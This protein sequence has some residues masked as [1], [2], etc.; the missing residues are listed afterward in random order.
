M[1]NAVLTIFLCS[2][3]GLIQ[4]QTTIPGLVNYW[5][6][7]GSAD[8]S[9]GVNHG[10]AYG[11]ITPT[12]GIDGQEGS[13]YYFDGI[14]D[15]VKINAN[16]P[17][18]ITIAFWFKADNLIGDERFISG[19]DGGSYA[20]TLIHYSNA[21]VFWYPYKTVV[22]KIDTNKPIWSFLVLSIDQNQNVTTYYNGKKVGIQ[23]FFISP[24]NYWGIGGKLLGY[25][26]SHFRGSMDEF[27]IFD[28]QITD[29][30]VLELYEANKPYDVADVAPMLFHN[31]GKIGVGTPYPDELLT[32]DGKIHG[33][34]LLIDSSVPVPDYVFEK[35]Y[36]LKTLEWIEKFIQEN[37]HLPN[38]PSANDIEREGLDLEQ[39]DMAML[40]KIEELTLYVIGQDKLIAEL[41]LSVGQLEIDKKELFKL[42]K[43]LEELQVAIK[44]LKEKEN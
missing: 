17:R 14:D 21:L 35:D 12:M 2:F 37:G 5:P 32:V 27:M 30:E 11:G 29:A 9:L 33:K 40:R 41:E 10:I 39:M 20:L 13:A 24:S 44:S 38:L 23:N 43:R 8:D 16:N 6:F 4:A 28:R 15:Y 34:E 7:N 31:E 26:G 1:R 25:Y 36:E 18:Q 3:C 22:S 42:A 19:M